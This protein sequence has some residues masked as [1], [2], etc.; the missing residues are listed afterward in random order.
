AQ[1]AELAG[2]LARADPRCVEQRGP[3]Q[4]RHDSAAGCD[5]GTAA[6]RVEPRV[7]DAPVGILAVERERDA[8][9][10]AAGGAARSAGT[11][12]VGHMPSAQRAFEMAAQ[13]LRAHPSECRAR[14]WLRRWPAR[15]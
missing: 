1:P 12:V 6:A 2:D 3:A 5:G 4:Q 9:Q 15:C 13:L 7:E 10:I 11:G 8:D 14:A